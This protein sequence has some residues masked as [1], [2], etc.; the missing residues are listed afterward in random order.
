[1]NN[2]PHLPTE[3][4]AILKGARAAFCLGSIM[5][6]DNKGTV[7]CLSCDRGQSGYGKMGNAFPD[8]S[9]INFFYTYT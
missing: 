3:L 7:Q 1:M 6:A 2:N 8:L 9:N 5:M 4:E